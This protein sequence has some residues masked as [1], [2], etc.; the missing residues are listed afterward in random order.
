MDTLVRSYAGLR[1]LLRLNSDLFM[2]ILAILVGMA[3]G[4][5]LAGLLTAQF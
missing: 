3:A 2:V 1:L 4:V 5:G